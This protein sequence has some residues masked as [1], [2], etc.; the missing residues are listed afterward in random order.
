MGQRKR[1]A[2]EEGEQKKRRKK[3]AGLVMVSAV[4]A[5]RVDNLGETRQLMQNN[6]ITVLM[7]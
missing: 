3:N 5:M 4:D 1:K 6:K 2:L 7:R